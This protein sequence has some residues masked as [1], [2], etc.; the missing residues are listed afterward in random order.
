MA[1]HISERIV[2]YSEF[3]VGPRRKVPVSSGQV[4]F[5]Q[6]TFARSRVEVQ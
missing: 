5:N 4:V 1:P 3:N 6:I 2:D